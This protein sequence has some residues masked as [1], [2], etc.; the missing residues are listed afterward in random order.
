MGSRN[1]LLRTARKAQIES[2]QAAVEEQK[3]EILLQSEDVLAARQENAEL[4]TQLK[5]EREASKA[6]AKEKARE[7]SKSFRSVLDLGAARKVPEKAMAMTR[8]LFLGP[9]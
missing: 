8:C 3:T 1:G 6:A 2:L 4:Q 7:R 9:H 5:A